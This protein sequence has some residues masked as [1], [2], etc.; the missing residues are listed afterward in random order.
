[1]F[2][3]QV[4]QGEEDGDKIWRDTGP[5]EDMQNAVDL[6]TQVIK[7]MGGLASGVRVVQV[8]VRYEANI[9]ITRIFVVEV[10]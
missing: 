10:E 7:E 3:L 2:Y 4:M 8:Q 1:M 5:F 9:E 6:G